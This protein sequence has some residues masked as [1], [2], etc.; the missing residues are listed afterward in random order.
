MRS[1]ALWRP[2]CHLRL[3]AIALQMLVTATLETFHRQ[4]ITASWVLAATG[5]ETAR[6]LAI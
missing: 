1:L 3:R 5:A 6:P 2:C 4:T